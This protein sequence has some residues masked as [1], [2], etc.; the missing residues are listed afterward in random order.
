[1]TASMFARRA[2]DARSRAALVRQA[3]EIIEDSE[4]GEALYGNGEGAQSQAG[5][6]GSP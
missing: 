1:M 2:E 3:V 6:N 5:G 4:D